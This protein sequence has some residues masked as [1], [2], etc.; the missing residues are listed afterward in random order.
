MFTKNDIKAI[1][2][3]AI[4]IPPC[5]FLETGIAK[6]Q[7]NQDLPALENPALRLTFISCHQ[8]ILTVR[9]YGV[10]KFLLSI[11]NGN[12]LFYPQRGNRNKWFI[13][14]E[15]PKLVIILSVGVSSFV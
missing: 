15:C 2:L 7:N 9:Q 10:E 13:R 14:I 6:V 8:D 11:E 5:E 3:H 12:F 1:Y 4:K